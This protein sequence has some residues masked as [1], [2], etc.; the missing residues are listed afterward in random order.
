MDN[1]NHNSNNTAP[2]REQGQHSQQGNTQHAAALEPVSAQQSNTALIPVIDLN[3]SS[4]PAS[5]TSFQHSAI[6]YQSE[7]AIHSPPELGCSLQLTAPAPNMDCSPELCQIC[8]F[9]DVSP[10]E[11][12]NTPPRY[13]TSEQVHNFSLPNLQLAIPA[14]SRENIGEFMSPFLCNNVV[15]HQFHRL[16]VARY[17]VA[18]Y[19]RGDERGIHT[20]NCPLCRADL[21]AEYIPP[22]PFTRLPSGPR[23]GIQLGQF[24]HLNNLTY[25]FIFSPLILEAAAP[26][27]QIANLTI[28]QTETDSNTQTSWPNLERSSKSITFL[29]DKYARYVTT[30]PILFISP[31]TTK[32]ASFP[33]TTQMTSTRSTISFSA[34]H[35]SPWP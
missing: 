17:I 24:G 21:R 6:A 2:H 14:I 3:S 35:I 32:F 7:S 25:S 9:S 34:S 33:C 4:D 16:C 27:V 22:Q 18:N 8:G 30:P 31:L 10:D 5:S 20:P 11:V 28:S 13:A 19:S 26:G 15:P 29:W 23:P 12:R 1:G